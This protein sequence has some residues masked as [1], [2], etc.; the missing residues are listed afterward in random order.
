MYKN[1]IGHLSSSGF[2][3]KHC[4]NALGIL[5]IPIE[6][7]QFFKFQNYF[8]KPILKIIWVITNIFIIY[9]LQFWILWF[10]N[11]K[12]NWSSPRSLFPRFQPL[13]SSVRKTRLTNCI[14]YIQSTYKV[15]K[16]YIVYGIG[17][18][19]YSYI[20]FFLFWVCC[21]LKNVL[22]IFFYKV[23]WWSMGPYLK[24]SKIWSQQCNL[25]LF[26]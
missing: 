7:F 14:I 9:F 3:W 10:G 17:E 2:F 6:L 8:E 13:Y 12:L 20:Y 21:L 22:Y 15:D 11:I 26:C 24:S 5:K 19:S 18:M 4:E 1:I 25:P 23:L 16:W